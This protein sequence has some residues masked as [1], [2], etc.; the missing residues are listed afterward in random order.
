MCLFSQAVD[1]HLFTARYVRQSTL[2]FFN[3][4]AESQ[5]LET[6][7]FSNPHSPNQE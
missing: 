3:D 1:V 5:A 2:T 4:T 7:I 6:E